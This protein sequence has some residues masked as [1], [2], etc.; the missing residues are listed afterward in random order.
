MLNLR[1]TMDFFKRSGLP[2]LISLGGWQL[3]APTPIHAQANSSGSLQ[4]SATRPA[5]SGMPAARAL[6]RQHCVKCHGADGTG[7]E[8]R[9][10]LPEI[11]NFTKISWQAQ[12]TDTRLI[13]SILDGKGSGMPPWDGKI[14]EEQARG[15][16]AYVR[17]FAPTVKTPG[18]GKQEGPDLDSFDERLRRLR[19]EMDALQRQ[20]RELTKDY[21]GGAPSKP[22][23]SRQHEVARQSALAAPGATAPGKQFRKRCVKCHGE[24]GTGNR[25][26]GELPDIP[27]FTDASWQRR[28]S[29][30]QLMASILDGKETEMPPWRGKISE[31]QAR[32][33]VVHVRSFAP[34]VKK[35]G[36]VPHEGPA[37]VEP[38]RAKPPRGC[39]EESDPLTR[40]VPPNGGTPSPHAP[41]GSSGGGTPA[42]G[43][44]KE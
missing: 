9:G 39:V 1:F 29:D 31:E 4:R 2:I 18:Q 25:A 20:Y 19:E 21:A 3:S 14:S 15:L 5:A 40:G 32:G 30:A 6:F 33:L 28:R 11:P 12:W 10:G 38:D 41:D 44:G 24:D 42:H 17:A 27:N 43:Q 13:A 7:D 26:R 35:S 34:T 36:Q 37:S 23:E 22:A 8:A 16:V